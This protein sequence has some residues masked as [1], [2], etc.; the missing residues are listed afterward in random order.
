MSDL[1]ESFYA[2]NTKIIKKIPSAYT[3]ENMDFIKMMDFGRFQNLICLMESY[4]N[5]KFFI[6][7]LKGITLPETGSIKKSASFIATFVKESRNHLNMTN[8]I[9]MRGDE[10]VKTVLLCIAGAIPRIN[11]DVFADVFI[12][13]NTKY[14]SEFIVWMKILET[15]SF[16]T[17]YINHDEKVNFMKS[18]IR[19]EE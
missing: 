15:P 5:Y 10:I 13:L 2:L 7:A 4:Q 9:L 17:T 16:P 11:V 1:L 3:S 18:I 12:T 6:A 8:T 14:P 19:Y